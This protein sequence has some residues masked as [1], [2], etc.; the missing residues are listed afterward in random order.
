MSIFLAL[1]MRHPK[2]SWRS[3]STKRATIVCGN[4]FPLNRCSNLV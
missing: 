3:F 1:F 4:I 2:M